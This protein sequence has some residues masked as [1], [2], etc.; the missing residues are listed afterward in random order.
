MSQVSQ[1]TVEV[2]PSHNYQT[3][4]LSFVL[5]WESP[6]SVEDAQNQANEVFDSLSSQAM[7]M[8][9][10]LGSM[11]PD[12]PAPSA[13]AF[14]PAPQQGA[15]SNGV[16]PVDE[17][18]W[19]IAYKPN[20]AGSFR[21]IPSSVIPKQ[22]FIEM[23]TAKLSEFSINPA[24]VTVFDDRDGSRGIESGGQHYCVGKVKTK[25]DSNLTAAMQGKQILANV[26][27]IPGGDVKVSLSRDGKAALQAMQIAGQLASLDA[28][29][30]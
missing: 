22:R 18:T 17:G 3:V 13:P 19:P 15:S 30:F 21:Y 7:V 28:T 6:V 12:T 14:A 20:G 2:R 10:A 8:V 4:G 1:I 23:V 27:F 26:D 25:P 24:E 29:P 9:E 5:N 16:N 11:K